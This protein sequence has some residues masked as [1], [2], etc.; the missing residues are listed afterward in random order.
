MRGMY[1]GIV[2]DGVDG[3]RNVE[4]GSRFTFLT[5][6][7]VRRRQGKDKPHFINQ[8]FFQFYTVMT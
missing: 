4:P 8:N 5:R 3:V 2:S 1:T 6:L 7:L